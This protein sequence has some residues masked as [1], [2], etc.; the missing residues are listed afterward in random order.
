MSESSS[1][2]IQSIIESA[3][4][5]GVELDE[6]ATIQW[7]AAMAANDDADLVVDSDSGTF[8][9]K[10]SMLD[11]SGRDLDRFRRIGTIVEV[12][13]PVGPGHDPCLGCLAS[14]RDA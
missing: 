6:A 1:D 12:T 3:K 10:V 7:L 2:D 5:L 14:R 9:H 4:R 8:G 11:F 13:G